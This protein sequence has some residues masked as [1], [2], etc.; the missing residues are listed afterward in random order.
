MPKE[1][2]SFVFSGLPRSTIK[3]LIKLLKLPDEK[4]K[5]LGS[6]IFLEED[7]F[8]VLV[9]PEKSITQ[10]SSYRAHQELLL[11]PS[12]IERIIHKLSN[13]F[14]NGKCEHGNMKFRKTFGFTFTSTN[15]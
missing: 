15:T 6:D 3:N 4:R 11:L 9:T 7:N 12:G 5:L 8:D 14:K 1:E 13:R 2:I 10:S